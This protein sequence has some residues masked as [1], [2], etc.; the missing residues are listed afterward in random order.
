LF[1]R[2]TLPIDSASLFYLIVYFLYY[3]LGRNDGRFGTEPEGN[4]GK[5]GQKV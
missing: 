5:I 2:P 3:S 1:N 4:V